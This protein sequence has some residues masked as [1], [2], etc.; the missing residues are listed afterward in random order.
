LNFSVGIL[1]LPGILRFDFWDLKSTFEKGILENEE[2]IAIFAKSIK[3]AQK[4]LGNVQ[5][6]TVN[7]IDFV[8]TFTEIPSALKSIL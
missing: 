4:N 6:L 2:L 5:C 3:T 1:E 8:T 7:V